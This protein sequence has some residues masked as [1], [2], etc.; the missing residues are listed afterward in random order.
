MQAHFGR[1]LTIRHFVSRFQFDDAA[2]KLLAL[3]ALAELSL[4]FTGTKDQNR[5]RITN[6][7]DYLVIRIS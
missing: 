4:G 2:T 5:F 1:K 3:D 7:S 6:T